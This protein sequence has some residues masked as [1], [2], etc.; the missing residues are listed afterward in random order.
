MCISAW[1]ASRSFGK[2]AW[3]CVCSNTQLRNA[4]P[5]PNTG[6]SKH[7]Q[8]HR[9]NYHSEYFASRQTKTMTLPFP[10]W[11]DHTTPQ[12]IHLAWHLRCSEAIQK[13]CTPENRRP[14]KNAAQRNSTQLN[15]TQLRTQRSSPQF[16]AVHTTK[17]RPTVTI[18][19][20]INDAQFYPRQANHSFYPRWI[21]FCQLVMEAA[22]R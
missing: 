6:P 8:G 4:A 2:L 18:L 20:W 15:S 7:N 12:Q 1:H 22:D 14:P 10:S 5:N 9:R 19:L 3:P 11:Q 17:V 13:I 21:N 16:T